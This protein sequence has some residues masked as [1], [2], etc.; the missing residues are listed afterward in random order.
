VPDTVVAPE[1]HLGGQTRIVEVTGT[2]DHRVEE[3][4]KGSPGEA[5]T[6]R[7]VEIGEP[8]L[9]PTHGGGHERSLAYSASQSVSSPMPPV[10]PNDANATSSWVGGVR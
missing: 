1:R 3:R 10:L 8:D 7:S 2:D 6:G 4:P 9:A 5:M